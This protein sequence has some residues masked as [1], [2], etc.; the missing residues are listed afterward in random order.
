MTV[1]PGVHA[2]S[3]PIQAQGAVRQRHLSDRGRPD[4]R[5]AGNHQ[6]TLWWSR[7]VLE[8]AITHRRRAPN[9]NWIV[10]GS[11]TGLGLA[12][13]LVG[14][15]TS[16]EHGGKNLLQISNVYLGLYGQDSWRLTKPRDG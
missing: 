16:L 3:L 11:A 4:A 5:A 7:S 15:I 1:T 12:D 2:L 8:R 9:G 6:F 10:N 14:R 13:L